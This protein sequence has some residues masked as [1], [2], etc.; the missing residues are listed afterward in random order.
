MLRLTP[1]VAVTRV[2]E[3]NTLHLVLQPNLGTARTEIL[4]AQPTT[5]ADKEGAQRLRL[6]GAQI[7]AQSGQ[8]SEARQQ[9][10]ELILAMP[11]TP[12]PM[13]GL[14][15]LEQGTGR[16]R[17]ALALYD[18]ALQLDPGNPSVEDAISEI[19]RNHGSRLRAD[20]EDP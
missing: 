1:G 11:G 9:F 3:K 6:L 14:A 19:Q 17:Q 12:E 20:F 8:V 7:M 2:D 15:G 10:G 18:R 5:E 4:P 13:S 16:W